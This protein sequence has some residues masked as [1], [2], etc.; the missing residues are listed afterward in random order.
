MSEIERGTRRRPFRCHVGLHAWFLDCGLI[1]SAYRCDRCGAAQ[2]R[3]A[4]AELA[5]ERERLGKLPAHSS[6]ADLYR[7]ANASEASR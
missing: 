5:A 6:L 7:A 2:D 4:T 3:D 1:R